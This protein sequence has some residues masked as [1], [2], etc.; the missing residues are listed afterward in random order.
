M[1]A[2]SLE[3]F[4][5]LLNGYASILFC[6]HPAVGAL[7]MA[8]TFCYPNIGLSGLFAAGLSVYLSEALGFSRAAGPLPVY[9]GLLV[10]LSLGMTYRLS[11]LT[12]VLILLSVFL[13]LVL[14][15]WFA[16]ALWR[17][18]HLPAL[19]APFVF[20]ML[21]IA[22]AGQSALAT[23]R[24]LAPLWPAPSWGPAPVNGFLTAL[25]SV[26]FC[27][28]AWAGALL[29]AGLLWSSR[30]LAVLAAAGFAAGLATVS[31]ALGRDAGR[32]VGGNG[33]NFI[34]TA[35]AVGGFFTIPGRAG[36]VWALAASAVSGILFMAF[37]NL[38]LSYGVPVSAFP[39]LIATL[40]TLLALKKR[41]RLAAP[42]L[43]LEQPD[44]P[45]RSL[46]RARVARARLGDPL[47]VPIHLP[48]YGVWQIYQGFNG[49]HTHQAPWQHA[50]DLFVVEQGRSFANDGQALGDYFAFGRPVCSPV[51]GQV[52][53]GRGDIADNPPGEING[54]QNWGN[55][56]LIRAATGFYVLLAHLKKGS[57]HVK[58]GDWVKPEQPL[59][60]C[61]NSGRSPQPHLHLHVQRD[62]AL[63]SATH[64]FHLVSVV[65]HGAGR[66]AHFELAACPRVGEAIEATPHQT[67]LAKAF[68]LKIGS[69]LRYVCRLP[70]GRSD[71]RMLACGADLQGNLYLESDRGARVSFERHGA[72][73]AFYNRHR[74]A[75]AFLDLWVLALGVTPL[76]EEEASWEDQPPAR[77]LPLPWGRRLAARLLEPLAGA[78]DSRY[79]SRRLPG[80]TRWELI[81]RHEWRLAP[82]L[83]WRAET[84]AELSDTEG[85][86]ALRLETPDGLCEA[87]LA[88]SGQ[89]ADEG[90]PG[91]SRIHETDAA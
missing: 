42:F 76:I 49:P 72:V 75:D 61:G 82:G 91:W 19:S 71:V 86:I 38:A 36:F 54:E 63:G 66:L 68:E 84:I 6:D 55:Y 67:R 52:V 35:M 40:P 88:A 29:L 30:Y 50:L 14:T 65:R 20:V 73:T 87:R 70:N 9:N 7:F 47:S 22:F 80:G 16:D 4:R 43:L 39:F 90:I 28:S 85:C 41:T 78:L 69:T 57:L 13:S 74:R 27:P 8:S 89:V 62:A 26:F 59:A 44:L 83:N 64:P 46:E 1:R 10:G 25:G 11:I 60:A 31:L 79:A 34:L 81:G 53:Q 18:G 51:Y 37:E 56:L 2:A 5:R 23:E 45:E 17:L 77:L 58:E 32:Y 24:Y 15:E 33:F 48:V 3:R 12:L 21:A